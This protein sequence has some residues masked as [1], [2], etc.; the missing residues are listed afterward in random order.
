VSLGGHG[1]PEEAI[2][3]RYRRSIQNFFRLY[4]PVVNTWRV[5]DNTQAGLPQVVAYGDEPG[6][7][8]ILV[9]AAWQQLQKEALP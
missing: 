1:V 9:E 7:E 3:R 6:N 5:Y 8:V 4:R 2:R